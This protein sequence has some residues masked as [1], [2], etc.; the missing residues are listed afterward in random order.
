MHTANP[1]QT[2][3]HAPTSPR[4]PSLSRLDASSQR[5]RSAHGWPVSCSLSPVY[6]LV[7][8][9][10]SLAHGGKR[11]PRYRCESAA[12][13][14]A[15]VGHRLRPP[16][17][18]LCDPPGSADANWAVRKSRSPARPGTRPG[19]APRASR[20]G[21]HTGLR[22]LDG[23]RGRIC[24]LRSGL[25]PG[26]R[27]RSQHRGRVAS[28]PR[29]LPARE[30]RKPALAEQDHHLTRPCRSRRSWST[31][32]AAATARERPPWPVPNDQYRGKIAIYQPCWRWLI[33]AHRI[34]CGLQAAAHV[35]A[36]ARSPAASESPPTAR[37]C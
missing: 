5:H 32:R 12:L 37:Q 11:A 30:P 13:H 22:R 31:A 14:L 7:S 4:A 19:H 17:S 36:A 34:S 10:G 33:I 35:R 1:D 6:L 24:D 9:Q 2:R 26:Q 16:L 27:H 28:E 3:C 29:E 25:G 8:A 15:C 21:W 18:P 23:D 20:L